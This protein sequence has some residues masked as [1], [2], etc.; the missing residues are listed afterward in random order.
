MPVPPSRMP[1]AV[2]VAIALAVAIAVPASAFAVDH[3]T[4]TTSQVLVAAAKKKKKIPICKKHQKSTKK[5]PC[6]KR[7]RKTAAV[8]ARQNPAVPGWMFNVVA[9]QASNGSWTGT[10]ILSRRVGNAFEAHEYSQDFP[11]SAWSTV[12]PDLSSA[13]FTTTLWDLAPVTFTAMGPLTSIAPPPGCTGGAWQQRE[14][15]LNSWGRSSWMVPDDNYYHGIPLPT[16]MPATLRANT[17]GPAT[18][19]TPPAPCFH[20]TSFDVGNP[21]NIQSGFLFGDLTNGATT[22]EYLQQRN[23]SP[24]VIVDFLQ[25]TNLP[26][27]DILFGSNFATGTISTTGSTAFTG[28]LNFTLGGSLLHFPSSQCPGATTTFGQ[29]TATGGI[30]PHFWATHPAGALGQSVSGPA[31]VSSTP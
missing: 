27:G 22:L 12:A 21:S 19:T 29:G 18:C 1:R 13:T 17:G 25:E 10:S 8:G 9:N 11:S 20:G 24:F 28:S 26:A 6:R 14:G 7:K 4:L 16:S 23:I 31:F 2:L 15:T 5:H 3:V 30:V